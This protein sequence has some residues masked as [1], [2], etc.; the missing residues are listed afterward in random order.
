MPN[1]AGKYDDLCTMVRDEADAKGAL[2][3]VIEGSKGNG[4]SAQLPPEN[5][6]AIPSL[7]RTVADQIEEANKERPV[8]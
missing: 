7:L 4:F 6:H 1:G 5:A 3:I 8:N 2:V